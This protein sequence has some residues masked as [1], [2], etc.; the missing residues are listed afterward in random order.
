MTTKDI[1]THVSNIIEATFETLQDVYD[2]SKERNLNDNSQEEKTL[3]GTLSRII[4]PHYSTKYRD[5]EIRLSE[6]ELRFV[7][8]EK[9]NQYCAF[10]NLP[11]YYSVETPTEEKYNQKDKT[12]LRVGEGESAMVD[13]TIHDKNSKRLAL[14]EFKA[15]NPAEFCFEKDFLKLTN[16]RVIEDCNT[17]FVMFVKNYDDGTI[18]SLKSKTE[19]KGDTKFYCWSL[20][21]KEHID[22]KIASSSI[23]QELSNV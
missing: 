4:F 15:L 12:N 3:D 2:N 9:F 17:F 7:F 5:A 8:V 16:E 22:Q 13:L 10:K 6:Q 14:I 18:K 21:K 23:N 19:T 1:E 20:E 11:W